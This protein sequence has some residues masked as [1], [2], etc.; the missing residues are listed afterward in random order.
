MQ[1]PTRTSSGARRAPAACAAAL[2]AAASLAAAQQPPAPPQT[3]A[4]P[5]AAAP[6]SGGTLD[7]IRTSGQI[8][9]G[10]RS[11]A[12]PFSFQDDEATA[13]GYTAR[14]C[15]RV[16]EA[17]AKAVGRPELKVA[18][19]RVAAD[20]RFQSVRRGDVD[21][22]CGA[23][24][25]TLSRREEVSFSIAIFPGGI[26]ALARTDVPA[27]L[28]DVLEGRG[29]TFQ[30]TWRASASN[31]LQARAFGAVEGTTTRTW[32][33]ERVRDLGIISDVT[34]FPDYGA[35][36][37]ALLD[38]RADVLFGE[39]AILMDTARRHRRAR[40]LR[41]LDRLFTNEALALAVPRGDDAFRLA[42][43]RALS[44]IYRSGDLGAMYTRWFG[45][46][47]ETALNFFRWTA[48]PE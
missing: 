12:R 32:L 47:D 4:A 2:V 11:D 7:R 29:Q 8:R 16:V 28:R 48:L 34:T 30:P 26:G 10:Y 9:L 33:M 44:G 35:G 22:L 17:L 13:D 43:D 20:T 42:V 3:P 37:E 14:L 46:P 1:P 6:A 24:S 41:V 38:R 39:R 40:D 36:I 31:V 27:R 25:V 21:L 15:E 5:A 23:D 45:E 19:T 18:W